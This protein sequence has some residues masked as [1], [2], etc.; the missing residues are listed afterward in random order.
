MEKD[1]L[2]I[3]NE[4]YS[5]Y[6]QKC[7][8]FAKSY[9]HHVESA[10]DFASEAML[11]LWENMNT[12][13]DVLNIQAFLFTVV[14]NKS[15]NYLRHE[16]MRF[17]VYESLFDVSQRELELRISTLESCDPNILFSEE[18]RSI[19]EQTLASLSEQTR[20]I[21]NMSRV[22]DKSSKEIAQL[23]GLTV[24]G[25]D[26]HISKVLRMLRINLKD[27]IPSLLFLLSW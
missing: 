25:V 18:V 10:E 17:E 19:F 3:F 14:K 8:L 22:E 15:L 1:K 11:K 21:F 26:Y 9:V 23:L 13:D 12:A 24:K 7:F 27:Y 4:I 20:R 6:Y 2:K 5:T 16:Q